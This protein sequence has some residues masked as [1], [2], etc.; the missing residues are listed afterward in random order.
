MVRP[1]RTAPDRRTLVIAAGAAVAAIGVV[2]AAFLLGQSS[3]EPGTRQET[4]A[5]PAPAAAPHTATA[6]SDPETAATEWLRA[7]RAVAYTDQTATAWTSRVQPVITGEL[8]QQTRDLRGADGG[9]E[10]TDFVARK[11]QRTVRDVVAIV[12]GEA[13]R[14]PTSAFVQVTGDVVTACAGGDPDQVEAVAAT[15]EVQRGA[16]GGW[17]VAKRLF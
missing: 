16:D 4:P 10:W 2:V 13:P 7:S 9:T 15:I 5:A 8:A 14:G 6:A 3:R 12:P 11:C 1:V 17:R